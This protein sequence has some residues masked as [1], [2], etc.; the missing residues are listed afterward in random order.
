M[1]PKKAIVLGA[2]LQPLDTNQEGLSLREAQNQKRKAT[3][4]TPQEQELDQEIRYLEAIHQQVQGK[5]EKML[6]LAKLQRKID[7]AP[8][9]MCHIMQEDQV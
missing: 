6:R 5:R 4:P 8:K 1:S 3:N 2:T 9:E 7:E